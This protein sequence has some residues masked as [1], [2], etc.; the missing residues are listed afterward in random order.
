MFLLH[1]P[2]D[3]EIRKVLE[4]QKDQPLSYDGI[5]FKDH[6]LAH[7]FNIDHHRTAL[8]KGREVFS[9]AIAAIK[10]WEMFN[11]GWLTLCWPDAAIEPD[12]MVAVLARHMGFWSL[13]ACRIVS[14]IDDYDPDRRYGF[15]Y[16][17]LPEHVECGEER[18]TVEWRRGDDTVW[19][20]ILAYSR[21]NQ[22]LA[23]LGYPIARS[24]QH[25]FARDSMAAMVRSVQRGI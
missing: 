6:E 4:R 22:L 19:Y 24:L 7:G 11:I 13:N 15:V 3:E 14:V 21:P 23:K 12:S 18:F 25:R 9:K 20:D 1:R 10:S 5:D 2:S 16:G 17:T 8:G